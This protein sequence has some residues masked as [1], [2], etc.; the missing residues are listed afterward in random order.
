MPQYV[1]TA[2]KK[3][4]FAQLKRVEEFE[5]DVL[6]RKK[7]EFAFDFIEDDEGFPWEDIKKI[8]QIL[9]EELGNTLENLH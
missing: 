5:E 2:L 7:H 8:D 1:D 9:Q 6:P 4:P 3:F